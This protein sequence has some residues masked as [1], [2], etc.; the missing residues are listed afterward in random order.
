MNTIQTEVIRLLESGFCQGN[1]AENSHGSSV[2][3]GDPTA[4]SWC[5]YGATVKAHLPLG[6]TVSSQR[7][8]NAIPEHSEMTDKADIILEPVRTYLKT[9]RTRS[10]DDLGI[11]HYN[12]T[13]TQAE[14]IAMLREVW[15]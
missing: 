7:D 3:A 12:D 2:F 4:M 6:F 1:N 15:A 9:H 5:L 11:A 13:H 10:D 14:V 8:Y